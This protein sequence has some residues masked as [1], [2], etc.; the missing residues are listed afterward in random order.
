[1][2]FFLEK[3][4]KWAPGGE[5]KGGSRMWFSDMLGL[6]AAPG[7]HHSSQT[8]PQRPQDPPNNDF[9]W[10]LVSFWTVF[11][12]ISASLPKMNRPHSAADDDY[13]PFF[14]RRFWNACTPLVTATSTQRARW[15][16][17]PAGQL[18][19]YIYIY[20]SHHAE[21]PHRPMSSYFVQI[22]INDQA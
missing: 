22:G 6:L 9:W 8:S 10:F 4:R 11:C 21:I 1:M 3:C 2:F 7:G 19:I 20:I 15:R 14:W 13:R 5:P 12:I 16:G 17:W 18:D